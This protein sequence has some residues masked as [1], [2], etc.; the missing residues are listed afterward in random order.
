M[1]PPAF[2]DV[3]DT[4]DQDLLQAALLEPATAEHWPLWRRVLGAIWR[5]M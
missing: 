4:I 3:L 2:P 1:T 5:W